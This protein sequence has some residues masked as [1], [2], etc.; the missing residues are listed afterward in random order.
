MSLQLQEICN[1][2]AWYQL[3]GRPTYLSEYGHRF[4]L[5]AQRRFVRISKNRGRLATKIDEQGQAKI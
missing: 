5:T 2:H 1:I 4:V 3:F